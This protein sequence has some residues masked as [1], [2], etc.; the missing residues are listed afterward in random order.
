[1]KPTSRQVL[2][3]VPKMPNGD[4]VNH[5]MQHPIK[6]EKIWTSDY[7]DIFSGN[8]GIFKLIPQDP[9]IYECLGYV[10]RELT[11]NGELEQDFDFEKYACLHKRYL[12]DG[13]ARKTLWKSYV[14]EGKQTQ[15]G[16]F[17]I[18]FIFHSLTTIRS[19]GI[20]LNRI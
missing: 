17:R 6:L 8:V 13:R 7:K 16:R 3:H 10:A 2:V 18:N 5:A 12:K 9:N 20:V 19:K 1:M 15:K 11:E 14:R 4:F